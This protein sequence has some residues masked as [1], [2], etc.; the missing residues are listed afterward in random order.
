MT[1]EDF[2]AKDKGSES[3]EEHT[4]ELLNLFDAFLKL[5]GR[6]FSE[7]RYFDTTSYYISR[8]RKNELVFSVLFI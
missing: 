3:I 8:F 5:Y 4:N 1:K 7:K 6:N 2:W